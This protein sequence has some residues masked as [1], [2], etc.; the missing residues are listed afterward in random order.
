[1]D[2]QHHTT[3]E[4]LDLVSAFENQYRPLKMAS[5]EAGRIPPE[6]APISAAT[7]GEL[8]ESR[9]ETQ[10]HMIAN[11]ADTISGENRASR[12][13]DDCSDEDDGS[14]SE[15]CDLQKKQCVSEACD[16]QEKQCEEGDCGKDSAHEEEDLEMS[17]AQIHEYY[18]YEEAEPT[19]RF[20]KFRRDSLVGRIMTWAG[21]VNQ[22][23]FEAEHLQSPYEGYDNHR[24]RSHRRASAD[25]N[26]RPRRV[27]PITSSTSSSGRSRP[28]SHSSDEVQFDHSDRSG[29]DE[30]TMM[31]MMM[32]HHQDNEVGDDM[33]DSVAN[34]ATRRNS[35]QA[36]VEKA[37]SMINMGPDREP[38]DLCPFGTRRD[39]L[40]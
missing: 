38:D 29:E 15:A 8:G 32:R 26:G 30:H 7:T 22:E 13:E 28:R 16:L 10:D 25:H 27:E 20:G 24:S 34:K 18:G 40:F 36:M 6:S 3:S 5:L 23:Y 12:P 4:D 39:S 11:V 1:M 31:A 35:L 14:L 17:H 21:A 2:K 9:N 19:T 37:M 33:I